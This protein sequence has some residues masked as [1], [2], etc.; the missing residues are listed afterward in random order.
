DYFPVLVTNQILGGSFGS[1]LNMNLRE[2]HGFTYGARTSTGADKY[3]SRFIASTSV[4][5]AVTDSAVVETMKEINR[6]KTELVDPEMLENSKAKFAG[7]FVLR[8]ENPATIANYALNIE[9]NDLPKDF[10]ETYLQR[11]NAVTA[12]DIKRVANKYYQTDKMRIVIAGKGTDVAESLENLKLNDQDVPVKYFNTYG[13]PID[14]PDYN[15]IVDPSV[16]AEN[17]FNKYLEAIGGRTAVEGVKSVAM[18][19]QA[20]IQGQTLDLETKTTSDPKFLQTVS[21]GGNAIS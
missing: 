18:K 5:N 13:E 17:V 14:K 12:E 1:Y 4:R 2:K 16:T 15:K 19:A 8:L 20:S 7:D 3:A 9:T 11:I 10:Y 21:M 6:I